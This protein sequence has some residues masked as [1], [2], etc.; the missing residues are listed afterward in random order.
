MPEDLQDTS[1]WRFQ[2][3]LS[4]KR[5]QAQAYDLLK[6]TGGIGTFARTFFP[7]QMLG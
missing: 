1:Y 5:P 7:E 6:A 3:L 2:A 4:H